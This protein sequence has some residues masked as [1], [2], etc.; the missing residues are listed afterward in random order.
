MYL[1]FFIDYSEIKIIPQLKNPKIIH[2]QIWDIIR[3][4]IEKIGKIRIENELIELKGEGRYVVAPPS[5]GSLG[6]Y[7]WEVDLKMR[8]PQPL[9]RFI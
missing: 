5:Q 6:R 2:E 3:Q 7:E 4:E 9:P 1:E 8:P